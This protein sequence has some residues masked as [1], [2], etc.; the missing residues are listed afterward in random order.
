MHD[1]GSDWQCGPWIVSSNVSRFLDSDS[2]RRMAEEN[3]PFSIDMP[4]SS[5]EIAKVSRKP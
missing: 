2:L 5:N 4:A 1:A 3:R